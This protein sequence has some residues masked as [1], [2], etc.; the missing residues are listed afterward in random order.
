MERWTVPNKSDGEGLTLDDRIA[1]DRS[2][3]IVTDNLE[4][5]LR[6]TYGVLMCGLPIHDE[7]EEPS[8]VR[9]S[10]AAVGRIKIAVSGSLAVEEDICALEVSVPPTASMS[11]NWID[12]PGTSQ[13]HDLAHPNGQK[14]TRRTGGNVGHPSDICVI[15]ASKVFQRACIYVGARTDVMM[16]GPYQKT[17]ST[18]EHTKFGALICRSNGGCEPETVIDTCPHCNT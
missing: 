2:K 6:Y 3:T 15:G 7:S 10:A 9:A 8:T 14:I 13:E 18:S 17:P 16:A 11:T 1:D 12:V 4:S 5:I